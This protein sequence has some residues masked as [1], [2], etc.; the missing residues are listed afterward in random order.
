MVNLTIYYIQRR[1]GVKLHCTNAL[2]KNRNQTKC[3]KDTHQVKKE[4]TK[5]PLPF[6]KEENIMDEA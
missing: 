2:A 5:T 4:H 6:R 3:K 1:T